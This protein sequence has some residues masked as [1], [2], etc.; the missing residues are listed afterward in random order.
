M[1][2]GGEEAAFSV[3][4]IERQR[5]VYIEERFE[6]YLALQETVKGAV[7]YAH[8]SPAQNLAQFVSF[9]KIGSASR[10]C[11]IRS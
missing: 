2:H 6:R 4:K 7:N 9:V 8:P 5:V 10:H 1:H 3:E 11:P